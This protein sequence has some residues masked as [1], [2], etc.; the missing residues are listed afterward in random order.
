MNKGELVES[1][2]QHSGLSQAEASRYLDALLGVVE[3]NLKK[4]EE[5]QV[6]GFGKF[7]VR[8]RAAREGRNP[9]TGQPM[10]IAASKTPV[11]S[12]GKALKDAV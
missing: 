1:V 4:G 9:Q 12:A 10:Q 5:I 2:A 8:E 7:S 6:T 3:E 11:F